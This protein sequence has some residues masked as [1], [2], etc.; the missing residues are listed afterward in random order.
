MPDNFLRDHTAGARLAEQFGAGTGTAEQLIAANE[1]RYSPELTAASS[2]DKNV[3][4]SEDVDWVEVAGLAGVDRKR[5]LDVAVRGNPAAYVTWVAEDEDGRVFKGV[6][7]I[8]D[9]GELE[10]IDPSDDPRREQLQAA[11]QAANAVAEAQSEA[12]DIVAKAKAEAERIVQKAAQKAEEKAS[13]ASSGT[14]PENPPAQQ[15]ETPDSNTA[16]ADSSAGA[17]PGPKAGTR[18]RSS[19]KQS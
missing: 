5:L 6:I 19:A 9:D 2:L 11:A 13:E 1:L 16:A 10:S 15:A 14:T 18:S 7:G 8:D 12:E 3:A 17:A 4:A